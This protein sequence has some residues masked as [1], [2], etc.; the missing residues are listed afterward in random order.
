MDVAKVPTT[1]AEAAKVLGLE[2]DKFL[3]TTEK[4]AK[5]LGRAVGEKV[6]LTTPEAAEFLRLSPRTL[7]RMRVQG[8][9]P[10]F[11]KLGPGLRARVV[12]DLEDLLAWL[13]RSHLSTSEF[14]C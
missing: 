2:V 10:R 11:L 5:F 13:Q 12:Y 1:T 6:L 9:G 3:L 14:A 7:E 4:A 8:T